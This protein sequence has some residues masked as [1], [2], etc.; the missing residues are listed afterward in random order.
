PFANPDA[1][2][3]LGETPAADPLGAPRAL[4]YATFDAWRERAGS[5]AAL[6]AF[7]GT[8]LTL[9]DPGVAERVSAT[10]VTPG[11]PGLLGVSAARGRWFDANDAG[12]AVVVVSHAFWRGKL[13]AD[14]AVVGR[15]I[16]LGSRPYTIVGVLPERFTFALNPCDIW[17]PLPVTADP[18][19]RADYRV[20][21]IARLGRN[22]SPALLAAALDDVSGRSVPPARV[23]ATAVATAIAGGSTRT[24]ALL[25]GAAALGMFIAFANLAGLLIV[26]SIDRRRE[27]AVRSALGARR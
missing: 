17:R 9:T 13:A 12:Q 4:R 15:Q 1:L 26:R 2:V 24:L 10:D 16:V 20:R 19:A 7:D 8:N 14:S 21:A 11:F 25:A 5:L 3:V 6:E 27:L 23:V 22:A 18:A